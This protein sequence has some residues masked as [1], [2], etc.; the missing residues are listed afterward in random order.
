MIMSSWGRAVV[1]AVA[2]HHHGRVVVRRAIA[3]AAG[4]RRQQAAQRRQGSG[5]QAARLRRGGT[6]GVWE[7]C[8]QR[9]Q[10]QHKVS[11]M[12]RRFQT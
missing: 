10:L 7:R 3:H 1:T 2:A 4:G 11:K 5:V 12:I 9:R 8:R 6:A